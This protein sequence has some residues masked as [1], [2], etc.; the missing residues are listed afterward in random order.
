MI[1]DT[2]PARSTTPTTY[3]TTPMMGTQIYPVTTTP[4]TQPSTTPATYS[5]TLMMGTQI[6]PVTTTP[7]TLPP[8]RI[9]VRGRGDIDGSGWT[10]LSDLLKA[11]MYV[12]GDIDLN[13]TQLIEAD[14][15]KDG[16]VDIADLPAM[17]MKIMTPDPADPGIIPPDTTDPEVT[18]PVSTTPVTP[19]TQTTKETTYVT[20]GDGRFGIKRGPD[21][22]E[23]KI[24]ESF[25]I[26]GTVVYGGGDW[27]EGTQHGYWDLFETVLTPDTHVVDIDTSEFNN[28]VPGTYKIT[29]NFTAPYF[30][31]SATI[32]VTV[33][34]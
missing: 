20:Y 16:V 14:M 6:N 5:T 32:T 10:D 26:T 27:I 28:Q 23:Y 1:V 25:D 31:D 4:V 7:V 17:R 29:L 15:T 8:Q 33:V 30:H 3:S 13:E 11:S 19:F 34:E 12:L 24:G 21:K 2:E 22:T 18:T 9:P